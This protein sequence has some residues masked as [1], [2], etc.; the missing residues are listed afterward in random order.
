GSMSIEGQRCEVDQVVGLRWFESRGGQILM[1]GSPIYLRGCIRGIAAH[2]HP[3]FTGL[4]DAEW[5]AKVIDAAKSFGFNLI[6]WHSTIPS[7]VYLDQADRLGMLNQ[8]ELGYRKV[9]GRIEVETEL[10]Q[11]MITS[12]CR[13]PSVAIYCVGNEI[14]GAGKHAHIQT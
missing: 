8:I 1:N 5:H 3:N 13:H 12:T 2:D 7:E 11:G 10:W 4:P 14:R 9:D 6:R